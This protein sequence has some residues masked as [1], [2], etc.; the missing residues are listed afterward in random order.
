MVNETEVFQF[1]VQVEWVHRTAQL[2]DLPDVGTLLANEDG[3]QPEVR[4]PSRVTYNVAEVGQDK[5]AFEARKVA[6]VLLQTCQALRDHM[7]R[8]LVL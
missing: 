4:L 5:D 6:T 7:L 8:Y 2:F 3:L 1:N